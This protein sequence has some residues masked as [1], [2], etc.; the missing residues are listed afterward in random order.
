M[1]PGTKSTVHDLA[2]FHASGLVDAV[3]DS[4]ATILGICGGYQMLGTRIVD[5]VESG[6]G[7]AHGMTVADWR[8]I[9]G[10]PANADVAIDGDATK[11]LDRF[12]ERVGG[13]AAARVG[14][15]R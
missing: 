15:A 14:V 1:L 6:A 4:S 12:V 5:D 9:T 13:L 2:W 7:L 11:F 10:K 3:R 8:G